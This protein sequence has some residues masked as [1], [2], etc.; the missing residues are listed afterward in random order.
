MDHDLLAVVVE[1]GLAPDDVVE[2]RLV[3]VG[4]VPDGAARVH[5]DVGE[6]AA[7]VIQALLV[8]QVL[9]MDQALAV[10]DAGVPPGAF[11]GWGEHGG[12]SFFQNLPEALRSPGEDDTII[13]EA[14]GNVQPG[15]LRRSAA[16]LRKRLDCQAP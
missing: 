3:V 8:R 14:K 7:V 11:V 9:H 12:L 6:Q 13:A 4:V 10:L 1:H 15:N 2:L 16:F 5:G